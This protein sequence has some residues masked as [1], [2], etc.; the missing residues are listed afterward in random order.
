MKKLIAV[1]L[2]LALVC[3]FAVTAMAG[4]GNDKGKG[5]G[6][7]NG[8]NNATEQVSDE[9]EV[10]RLD[11]QSDGWYLVVNKD[12]VGTVAYHDNKTNYSFTAD[13]TAGRY[14]L[15]S[16]SGFT[17]HLYLGT[18]PEDDAPYIIGTRTV[19]ITTFE[20][21][22]F[23]LGFLANQKNQQGPK[24][25]Y[26]TAS[27]T[28]TYNVEVNVYDVYSD[29]KEVLNETKS[30]SYTD[31]KYIN[32]KSDPLPNGAETN[33]V[34]TFN[35]GL[36]GYGFSVSYKGNGNK[37]SW[38]NIAAPERVTVTVTGDVLPLE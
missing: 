14:Y 38:S 13:G 19:T 23:D 36:D 35:G 28:E 5:K 25:N 2:V 8:N 34:P 9:D 12:F 1:V 30:S 26:I 37:F 15:G 20:G 24:A 16:Q 31:Y 33:L 18:L 11:W 17:G 3:S 22:A 27:I 21:A 29:G 10:C 6:N 32:G 4:K 7:D